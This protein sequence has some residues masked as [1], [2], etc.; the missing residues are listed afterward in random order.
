M[1]ATMMAEPS[2][3]MWQNLENKV[4]RVGGTAISTRLL[5]RIPCYATPELQG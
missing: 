5:S 3:L 4:I 2:G 1:V